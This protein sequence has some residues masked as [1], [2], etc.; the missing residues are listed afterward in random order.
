MQCGSQWSHRNHI[1]SM[2]REYIYISDMIY[3]SIYG[4]WF[5]KY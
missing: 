1:W 4:V 3:M 5:S 2:Q